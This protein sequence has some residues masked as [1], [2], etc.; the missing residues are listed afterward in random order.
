MDK[1]DDSKAYTP[2]NP[3]VGPAERKVY[4]LRS[5]TKN[6]SKAYTP[7]NPN[8]GPAERMVYN[9]RSR[10]KNNSKDL[11]YNMDWEDFDNVVHFALTQY[12]LK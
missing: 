4:N 12:S 6:N 10:T 8:V 11:S 7:I 1:D 9:L 5:R 3:S 2:T